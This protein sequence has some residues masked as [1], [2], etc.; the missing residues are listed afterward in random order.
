MLFLQNRYL[1]GGMSRKGF[2]F[3]VRLRIAVEEWWLRHRLAN[4]D[5]IIVQ[6]PSTA[7]EVKKHLGWEARVLPFAP[8]VPFARAVDGS[9]QAASNPRYD[10]A[11]VASGEPHKNHRNLLE[12]WRLLAN[13]NLKPSL[14]VTVAPVLY[15]EIADWIEEKTSTEKLNVTNIGEVPESKMD[16]LYR[17]AGALIYPSF[18]ESLGLPLI[19][20]RGRG[21][22]ILA[23]EKDFVRDVVEPHETFDPHSAVSIARAVR[24]FLGKPE[25]LPEVYTPEQFLDAVLGN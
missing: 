15:P 22:P 19:E 20:A 23:A 14:C 11:Y 5:E 2:R 9:A 8:D 16:D 24:R 6:S 4:V 17:D 3:R 12:A 21:M 1:T 25:V 7:R 13:D 10:F 18:G